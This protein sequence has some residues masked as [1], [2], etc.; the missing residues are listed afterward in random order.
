[1]LR[2]LGPFALSLSLLTVGCSDD[3]VMIPC[4][5]P[6]ERVDCTCFD[7]TT[8]TAECSLTGTMGFC[9]CVSATDTGGTDAGGSDV[10]TGDVPSDAAT[11]AGEEDVGGS[12]TGTGDASPDTPAPETLFVG[13]FNCIWTATTEGAPSPA[14]DDIVIEGW[15]LGGGVVRWLSPG[16]FENLFQGCPTLH[17]VDGDTATLIGGEECESSI[18]AGTAVAEAD[19]SFI[20]TYS[21]G[22]GGMG[23]SIEIDCELAD[24]SG[25]D[26]VSA[27]EG[28]WSCDGEMTFNEDTLPGAFQMSLERHE[29]EYLHMQPTGGDSLFLALCP[30]LIWTPLSASFAEL[31]DDSECDGMGGGS[32]T[33]SSDGLMLAGNVLT[34]TIEVG[35]EGGPNAT[36]SFTCERLE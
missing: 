22:F 18:E 26:P 3:P 27:F 28:D 7:G 34:G 30:A 14:V 15:D 16:T 9:D 6:G 5:S 10:P 8:S 24:S 33:P 23:V 36:T 31:R 17:E 29:R 1:M 4:E 35:G 32:G 11:D 21:S 12:D 20:G 25:T 2:V 19:G 13:E